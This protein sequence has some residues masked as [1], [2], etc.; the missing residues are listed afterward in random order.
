MK[1][2]QGPLNFTLPTS[3]HDFP[4]LTHSAVTTVN[5]SSSQSS[6]LNHSNPLS[7]NKT[8]TL[9]TQEQ[10]KQETGYINVCW[11]SVPPI[12]HESYA[13]AAQ[14]LP[15][16]FRPYSIQDSIPHT[17]QNSPAATSHNS[18]SVPPWKH[19]LNPLTIRIILPQRPQRIKNTK[20]K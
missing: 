17:S 7:T 9:P 4:T 5:S 10:N 20:Q 6:E 15:Q 11:K 8:S 16:P 14:K 1:N 19:I 3:I 13:S 18:K 2:W 12:S